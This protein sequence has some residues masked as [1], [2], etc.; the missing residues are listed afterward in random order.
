MEASVGMT[1]GSVAEVVLEDIFPPFNAVG[2]GVGLCCSGGEEGWLVVNKGVRVLT[3]LS[4][5]ARRALLST[6]ESG[7]GGLIVGGGEHSCPEV[8]DGDLSV[9]DGDVGGGVDV[10]MDEDNKLLGI[11]VEGE[12]FEM[13]ADGCFDRLIG[14]SCI[15]VS[16]PV[17]GGGRR[18]RGSRIA[19]VGSLAVE[20]STMGMVVG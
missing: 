5:G 7:V 3:V 19:V 9:R 14:V 4:C 17:G 12:G 8:G 2:E 6:G 16:L 20:G 11:E 18:G 15:A 1:S 10:C 13:W